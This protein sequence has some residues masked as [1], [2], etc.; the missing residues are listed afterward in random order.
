MLDVVALGE[1]MVRFSPPGHQRIEQ[2]DHLEF[3]IGGTESNF[4]IGLSR[5][6]FG[7]AWISGLVDNPLGRWLAN[8]IRA[9]GVD[10]SRVVWS[11]E[12]RVGLYFIEFGVSPRAAEIIYD[13]ASS[14][15]SRLTPEDMDWD[16]V[17]SARHFHT[18]G[19]TAAISETCRAV[20]ARGLAEAKG[21]G[22]STSFDINYRSLL[23]S[24]QE[25][26]QALE[27]VLPLVDV[28]FITR[29]DA[30]LV[31][32]VQGDPKEMVQELKNRYGNEVVVVTMGG[33]GAIALAGGEYYR[34]RPY[35]VVE[36]D[37]VGAGDAF[38]AGFICGYLEGNL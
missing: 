25:A 13:R 33:E 9:H 8:R 14:A 11:A 35:K 12:G 10:I 34:G 19:I 36:V 7:V 29:A 26:K 38:D 16:F 18:T 32:G 3:K 27:E 15:A 21:A 17:R 2:A 24:P 30:G 1:T 28:L 6:G 22:M 5:L 37:R 4:A 20:V 31:F 23:W